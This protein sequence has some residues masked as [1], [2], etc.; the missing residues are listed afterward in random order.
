M[1]LSHALHLCK[2]GECLGYGFL[3]QRQMQQVG[4]AQQGMGDM[5]RFW[6]DLMPAGGQPRS[7]CRDG[8]GAAAQSD[9]MQAAG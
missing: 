1:R 7:N 3:L 6:L 9:L 2:A 8:A 5:L 4:T